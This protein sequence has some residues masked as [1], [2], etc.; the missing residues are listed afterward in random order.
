MKT[1]TLMQAGHVIP[2]KVLV[3][4][5]KQFFAVTYKNGQVVTAI[6]FMDGTEN[7][8]TNAVDEVDRLI[9]G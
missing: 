1:I 4:N 5:I 2:V 8:F 6:Q 3:Q 7:H 9:N